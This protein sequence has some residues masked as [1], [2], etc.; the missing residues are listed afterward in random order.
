MAEVP[1]AALARQRSWFD[2][3][4]AA[5]AEAATNAAA[6]AAAAVADCRCPSSRGAATGLLSVAGSGLVVASVPREHGTVRLHFAKRPEWVGQREKR[7]ARTL[8]PSV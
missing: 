8:E 4:T 1:Y 6:A 2:S 7:E 3:R 5:A